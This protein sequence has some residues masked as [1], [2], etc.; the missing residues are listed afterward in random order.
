MWCSGVADPELPWSSAFPFTLDLCGAQ[1]RKGPI[2]GAP[3][4]EADGTDPSNHTLWFLQKNSRGLLSSAKLWAE[5]RRG[6]PGQARRELAVLSGV[7][8]PWRALSAPWLCESW[9]FLGFPCRKQVTITS[10]A[11]GTSFL[12]SICFGS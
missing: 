12:A 9:S 4:E 1:L 11:G 7:R 2:V 10:F 3:G 8:G 5:E 6:L